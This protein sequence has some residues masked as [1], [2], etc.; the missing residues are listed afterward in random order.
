MP[1]VLRFLIDERYEGRK[2]V[3]YLRGEAGLSARLVQSLKRQPDGICLNGAHTRTIDS[4]HAGDELTVCLPD[5]GACVQPLDFPLQVL[6]EDEDLLL[7]NKPAGLAMH[8]TH[9]HQGDTLANAVAAY[10]QAQG[11]HVVMRCVGRLD[12][13]TSGVVVCALNRYAAARLSGKVEKEYLAAVSG[14]YEG[15]GTIT[16]PIIRPDPLHTSRAVGEGGLPAVTHWHAQMQGEGMTLLRIRLETG[17]THQIR[18]H[19]ASLGT[20]LVGDSM[21]GQADSRIARQA[22]HCACARFAHPVSGRELYVEAPLPPDIAAL[23]ARMRPL[24][25]QE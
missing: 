10:Y 24:P 3:H 16:R 21:Y 9:N 2:V 8:P 6:Y 19:F 14:R 17:R 18:V 1:R 7:V 5:D 11:R 15:S 22:L 20:P 12:R 4:L 25:A 23:C 13:D